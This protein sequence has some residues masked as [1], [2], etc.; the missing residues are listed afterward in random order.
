MVTERVCWIREANA[1]Q[2]VG[3]ATKAPYKIITFSRSEVA[4]R[5]GG[6]YDACRIL[7]IN[8]NQ[9]WN[10]SWTKEKLGAQH[11]LLS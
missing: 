9:N 3:V 8:K 10:T 1:K 5:F 11:G 7:S 4:L 6:V 2:F